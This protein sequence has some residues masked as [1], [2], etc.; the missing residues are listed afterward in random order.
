MNNYDR[1]A[2][3]Q[4][5]DAH[6]ETR[7]TR[8]LQEQA[9]RVHFTPV[10][11]EHMLQ[12]LAHQQRPARQLHFLV[13]ALALLAV[14]MLIVSLTPYVLQTWHTTHT[15]LQYSVS[16]TFATPAELAR[17][18]HLVSLD[19][20]GHYLLYQPAGQ[21][22]VLYTAALNDSL[23][24]NFLAMRYARDMAWAPDG[25]ALVATVVPQGA[26]LP[27]LALVPTGAYMHLLGHDALTASWSSTAAITYVTQDSKHPQ[28]WTTSP[29]G[30]PAHLLATMQISTLVQHL[31]WSSD[32]QELALITT[33][34]HSPSAAA[35]NHPSRAIYLMSAH[36]GQIQ[37][38]VSP[39]SFTIGTV[40]WSPDNRY[41]TYPSTDTQ[42][43]TTLQTIDTRTHKA[44]FAITLDQSLNGWSWSPDSNAIVYSDGGKLR[45]YTLHGP[46]PQLA[47]GQGQ[48][49]SPFWLRD[50]RILYIHI[51]NGIGS[52]ET[53]TRTIK[54]A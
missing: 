18:G 2:Q 47:Q 44:A 41:L 3:R 34:S 37:Q 43:K 42:G 35:L 9:E 14:L 38:I 19:P 46:S 52:L 8:T 20:T 53:M 6:L 54:H 24:S 1:E 48:Q 28:L 7:L 31:V 22:G 36:S 49:V 23:H 45:I 5:I 13:P 21:Q 26:Y 17:G 16:Q 40:G 50:G 30:K 32:G 11:R 33:I 10:I 15:T 4:P 51:I 29:T 39:G 12:H 27:L 25:S